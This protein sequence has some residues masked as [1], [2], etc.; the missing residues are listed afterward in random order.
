[1][2]DN[3]LPLC[4]KYWKMLFTCKQMKVYNSKIL[5]ISAVYDIP[6]YVR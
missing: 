3:Y 5:N 4:L 2:K 6:L 1:M